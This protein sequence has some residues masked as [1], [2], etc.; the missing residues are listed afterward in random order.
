MISEYLF[1]GIDNV[2]PNRRTQT[3]PNK[4]RLITK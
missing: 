4:N 3:K 2:F 1:K